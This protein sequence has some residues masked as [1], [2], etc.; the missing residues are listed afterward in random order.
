MRKIEYHLSTDEQVEAFTRK[1]L[2]LVEDIDPPQDLRASVFAAAVGLY[3]G[4]Q[5]VFEQVGGLMA[6]PRN[7]G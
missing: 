1:A 4:R 7:N 5:V 6:I 2:A 3:S